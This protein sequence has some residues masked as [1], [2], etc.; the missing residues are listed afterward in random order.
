ME[1]EDKFMYCKNRNIVCDV[2]K[3]QET[4]KKLVERHTSFWLPSDCD[5]K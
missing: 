5:L 3:K 4:K 1:P 2:N